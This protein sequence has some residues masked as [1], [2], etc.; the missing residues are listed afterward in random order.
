MYHDNEESDLVN[1]TLLI[2]IN[3]KGNKAKFR[4]RLVPNQTVQGT[5]ESVTERKIE[6]LQIILLSLKITIPNKI[7]IILIQNN[8]FI[9]IL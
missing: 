5:K 3:R 9:K 2:P 4:V 7:K 1:L 6:C 8:T